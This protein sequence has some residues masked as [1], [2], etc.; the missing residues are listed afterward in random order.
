MRRLLSMVL[1]PVLLVT[2]GVSV[3]EAQNLVERRPRYEREADRARI[4]LDQAVNMAQSRFRAKA[5]KAQSVN[6]GDQLVYVIRLLNSDG[7]VWTVR[8]DA[9]TGQIH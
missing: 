6:Q 9:Q 3:V 5:I 4:S 7:K 2:A 1:L 8:V